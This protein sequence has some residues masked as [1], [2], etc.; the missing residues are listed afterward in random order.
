MLAI[1]FLCLS[2]DEVAGIHEVLNTIPDELH[3][4]SEF[5]WTYLGTPVFVIVS[6]VF[7]RFLSRLSRTVRN[8]I[9]AAGII[10]GSGVMGIEFLS[11]LYLK[12]HDIDTLGYN[13]LTPLEEGLEMAGVIL[14]IHVLMTYMKT[15]PALKAPSHRRANGLPE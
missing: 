4:E 7:V 11:H 8:G 1:G 6:L 13:L 12:T 10:Y 3:G 9:C 5:N 2:L 15:I 14:F